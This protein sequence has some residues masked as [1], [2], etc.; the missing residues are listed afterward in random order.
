LSVSDYVTH[1]GGG[2]IEIDAKRLGFDVNT[3]IKIVSPLCT[4]RWG[5]K[6][7]H[8]RGIL[9]FYPERGDA[10]GEYAVRMHYA[11]I[12]SNIAR[13]LESVKRERQFSRLSTDHVVR[14]M[15][16]KQY[17]VVPLA[18]FKLDE[19]QL[20]TVCATMRSR[21]KVKS[22]VIEHGVIIVTSNS[23]KMDKA[24]M[25]DLRRVIIHKAAMPVVVGHKGQ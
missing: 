21:S 3:V 9:H 10:L 16:G 17:Q 15:G 11:Q 5:V 8:S 14:Y 13:A 25:D 2:V 6:I 7:N 19:Q 18:M 1:T 4:W 12:A 20:R 24:L 22:V 23:A